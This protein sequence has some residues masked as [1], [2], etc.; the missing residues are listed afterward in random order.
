MA[1]RSFKSLK[2]LMHLTAVEMLTTS[3]NVPRIF[4]IIYT[5][6]V[7]A[8]GMSSGRRRRSRA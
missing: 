5:R 6:G 8:A 1:R 2:Q 7:G 4:C 3:A